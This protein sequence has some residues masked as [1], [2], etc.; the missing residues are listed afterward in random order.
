MRSSS[1]LARGPHELAVNILLR[2]L[3]EIA[4]KMH[5]S[6][7]SA[8]NAQSLHDATHEQFKTLFKVNAKRGIAKL[9]DNEGED[10]T[11]SFLASGRLD[12]GKKLPSIE[13]MA[14]QCGFHDLY[15]VFYRFQSMHTH[16]NGV[17]G[18]GPQT[19]AATLSAV[20]LFCILL[21][22]IGI[23]WLIHRSRPD[24]EEVRE[25]LGLESRTQA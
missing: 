20:A 5:W 10:H 24:N 9:M 4:I 2:S 17:Q 19:E 21:G 7:L 11:E 13:Q 22:H 1:E 8:D 25:L 14:E 15:N 6:T 18:K 12:K 16:A 23:R 3:I